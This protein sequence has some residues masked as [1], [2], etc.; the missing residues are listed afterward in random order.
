MT[1]IETAET[2]ATGFLN[3]VINGDD[4]SRDIKK[5]LTTLFLKADERDEQERRFKYEPPEP[6]FTVEVAAAMRLEQIKELLEEKRILTIE[7]DSLHEKL[8]AIQI[9]HRVVLGRLEELQDDSIK[10]LNELRE[11]LE[12]AQADCDKAVKDI[13]AATDEA[14]EESGLNECVQILISQRDNAR[15]MYKSAEKRVTTLEADCAVKHEALND[16]AGY[17]VPEHYVSKAARK[18]LETN[19][20]QSLLD[21][22]KLA[23]EKAEALDWLE[24]DDKISDWIFS[25]NL[26]GQWFIT[27]P[28]IGV[29]ASRCETLLSAINQ[30]KKEQGL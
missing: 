16:I 4:I 2:K 22:L 24:K 28:M 23:K 5:E 27:Q 19:S 18:V 17:H 15:E 25:K 30:A 13:R 21:E 26:Q 9:Q 12:L 1:P 10:T 14:L 7:R 6:G 29:H 8:E 11:E 3:H 20:G